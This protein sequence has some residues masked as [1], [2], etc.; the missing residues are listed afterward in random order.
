MANYF[1]RSNAIVSMN[2]HITNIR[3]FLIVLVIWRR[4]VGEVLGVGRY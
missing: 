2:K 1:K 3:K 4:A